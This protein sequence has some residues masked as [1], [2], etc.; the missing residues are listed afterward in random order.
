MLIGLL[1]DSHDRAEAMKAAVQLLQDRGAAYL[2][3]CG[4]IGSPHMIDY[5]VGSPSAFVWGNCDWDR[6]SLARYAHQVGVQ[7][8]GGFGELLL[9]GKR[10]ALLHG[11]DARLK[12]NLLKAQE[13]DYLFQGHTHV[14]E[15][16]RIGRTRLINP[17]ALHRVRIRTVALLQ[18]TDDTLELLE[19]H[20]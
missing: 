4:D 1:S 6:M 10:M 19:V 5:L 20:P 3:H 13:H 12:Q 8:F 7:C 17:G 2:I 9:D 15:D 11:D 18:T 16:T 14:V